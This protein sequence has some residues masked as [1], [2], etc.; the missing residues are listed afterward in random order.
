MLIKIYLIAGYDTVSKLLRGS[1]FR[2][3]FKK[4]DTIAKE[5]GYLDQK[6]SS[7]SAVTQKKRKYVLRRII[8]KRKMQ[9]AT[10]TL[11][12]W[13][14]SIFRSRNQRQKRT[15]CNNFQRS[16]DAIEK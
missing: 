13:T 14:I 7:I 4:R 2:K 9:N 11:N 10:P 15:N 12:Y 16:Y 8:T 5:Q 6:S 1:L 3:K